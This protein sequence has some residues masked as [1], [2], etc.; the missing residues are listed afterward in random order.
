MNHNE[1]LVPDTVTSLVA[2]APPLE[3]EVHRPIPKLVAYLGIRQRV[4]LRVHRLAHAASLIT[5]LRRHHRSRVL[6]RRR[7]VRREWYILLLD[8]QLYK[9]IG[10]RHR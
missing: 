10:K 4:G 3:Q 2:P 5:T 9:K 8:D 1:T 6:Q 7:N